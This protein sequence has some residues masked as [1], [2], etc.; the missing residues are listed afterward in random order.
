MNG[1]LQSLRAPLFNP[2]YSC[3]MFNLA[4]FPVLR[5]FIVCL[6]LLY[7]PFCQADL[8][9]TVER[10]KPA[11]VGIGSFQKLHSPPVNF[12]GTGFVVEDGLHAITNA[13][14]ISD[15][16]SN[17]SKGSLIIMTGKGEKPELRNATIIALDKEHDLALLRFEGTALPA[18]KLGDAGT[19]KEGKLLAF[20]GFPI[21]MVLGFYP[22]THR[23]T[24][25]SITPVILPAQNARQLDAAKIRQL[26]KSAY[27]IFQLDGTAYPGNSGSPL[28]DPDT[29][30]V[31][32][33]VNMVFIKGKK[34]SILSDPSGISYA[35]PA[36]YVIDL[37]KH[38][39]F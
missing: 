27:K 5:L 12:L 17:T 10:I 16:S 38:G 11:I 26:Q 8:V 31:Y 24:I 34:E 7:S 2:F 33:V 23:A 1:V 28:Y 20:T 32:G 19:I 30:E 4:A 14:V 39:G 29:G 18:M 37:L 3:H 6:V 22:V 13:H 15:L 35:I 25:S 36:N 21:G 9:K